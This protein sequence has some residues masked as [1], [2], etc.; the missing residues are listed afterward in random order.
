MLKFLIVS[1]HG[2]NNKKKIY[3][4]ISLK[5]ITPGKSIIVNEPPF[6]PSLQT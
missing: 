2:I 5:I 3:R 6:L 1:L 4:I